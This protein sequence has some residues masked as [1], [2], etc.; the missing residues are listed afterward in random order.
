MLEDTRDI[1]N[2]YIYKPVGEAPVLS[3]NAEAVI[4][5]GVEDAPLRCAI[6]A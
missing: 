3:R 6:Q 5:R 1:G 2:E 4:S